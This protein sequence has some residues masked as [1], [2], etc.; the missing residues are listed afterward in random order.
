MAQ[1][2]VVGQSRAVAIDPEQAF[3][4]TRPE[5]SNRPVR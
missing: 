1:P 2:M 4:T 5:L 3:K